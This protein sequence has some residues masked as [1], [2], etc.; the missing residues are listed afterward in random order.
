M[1][2]SSTQPPV[3]GQ[4]PRQT[5][6]VFIS[7]PVLISAVCLFVILI[8]ML[9]QA[10][11]DLWSSGSGGGLPGGK[12]DDRRDGSDAWSAAER[13]NYE[14]LRNKIDVELQQMNAELVEHKREIERLRAVNFDE[15]QRMNQAQLEKNQ[16]QYDSLVEEARALLEE[17]ILLRQ[18][19]EAGHPDAPDS[20]DET[21][22][23]KTPAAEPP[24]TR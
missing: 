20:P 9:I 2:E 14:K 15:L 24:A 17:N 10:H 7:T 8:A 21:R 16:S 22:P 18:D 13:T 3:N 5:G 1:T 23:A 19:L 6:G 12:S 11:R 4:S